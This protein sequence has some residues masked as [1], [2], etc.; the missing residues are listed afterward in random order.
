MTGQGEEDRTGRRGQ[1]REERAAK[2]GEGRTGKRGQAKEKRG[3]QGG[4]GSHWAVNSRQWTVDRGQWPR[5]E[6]QPSAIWSVS[7]IDIYIYFP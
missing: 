4:E 5:T 3:D 1:D 2:G 6:W 7:Y